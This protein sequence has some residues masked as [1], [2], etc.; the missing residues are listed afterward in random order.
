MEIEHPDISNAKLTG[1]PKGQEPPR[2]ERWKA[3]AITNEEA[4]P[5]KYEDEETDDN[6][7]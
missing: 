1:Y 6:V 2:K 3:K 7:E 4:F 5:Y